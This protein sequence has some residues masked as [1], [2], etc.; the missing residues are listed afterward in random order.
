MN[1][2]IE[3]Q[4]FKTDYKGYTDQFY[5]G[6]RVTN[7]S[8]DFVI[9]EAFAALGGDEKKAESSWTDEEKQALIDRISNVS[10]TQQRIDDAFADEFRLNVVP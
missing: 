7:D 9:L 6:L 5:V 1:K 2:T 3:Y 4:N 10:F 8:D